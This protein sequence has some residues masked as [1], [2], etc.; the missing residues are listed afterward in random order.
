MAEKKMTGKKPVSKGQAGKVA[1]F[2]K[3][4]GNG[5][6]KLP[7]AKQNPVVTDDDQDDLQGA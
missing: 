3:Q 4:Q 6:P 1:N 2:L 5:G 7:T